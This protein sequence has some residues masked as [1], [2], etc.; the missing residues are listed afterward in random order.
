MYKTVVGNEGVKD[1]VFSPFSI[2]TIMAMLY[3]GMKDT[4]IRWAK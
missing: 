2:S 3:K 1:V 4:S